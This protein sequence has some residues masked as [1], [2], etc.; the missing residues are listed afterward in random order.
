M[1]AVRSKVV[2]PLVRKQL[3]N[4]PLPI[5]DNPEMIDTWENI[6]FSLLCLEDDNF[7]LIYND[8]LKQTLNAK[9][10]YEHQQSEKLKELSGGDT[11]IEE[12]EKMFMSGDAAAAMEM[13]KK[14]Q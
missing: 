5:S 10:I 9:E 3:I 4:A 14:Y 1:K 13:L 11:Y 2:F 7:D 12:M 8:H 6:E